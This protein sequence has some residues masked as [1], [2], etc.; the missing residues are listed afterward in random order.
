M[1]INSTTCLKLSTHH[2]LG[3]FM[4]LG[5]LLHCE[6][7]LKAALIVSA[8]DCDRDV[9]KGIHGVEYLISPESTIMGSDL[10]WR[11]Q[12]QCIPAKSCG[13]CR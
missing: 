10:Y 4:C 3:Y 6:R 8:E 11:A 5:Q 2:S 12:V 1:N 7:G 13:L 9:V